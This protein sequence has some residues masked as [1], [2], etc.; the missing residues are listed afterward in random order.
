MRHVHLLRHAKSSWDEPGLSDHGRPLAPRGRRAAAAMA[1][2]LRTIEA[3]PELVLCS[4]AERATETLDRIRDGL[5][6]DVDV[7]IAPDL[8]GAWAGDMLD[9]LSGLG[10][11]VRSVMMVG[12]NP[13]IHDLAGT[14]AGSG[15]PAVL[16]RLM[17]KYPTGALATLSFAGD[18]PDLA[19]GVCRLDAF[20]LPRQL[21]RN[22]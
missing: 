18:W 10:P 3:P 1:E 8:Y 21:K 20:V 9:L 2:H 15:D 6:D 17:T 19:A 13:G 22:G 7:V 14:L 12:H 16:D 11:D 4:S 5:P